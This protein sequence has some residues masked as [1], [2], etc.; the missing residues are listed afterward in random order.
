MGGGANMD[1]HKCNRTRK[2][3][4]RN[5]TN[6]KQI[7]NEGQSYKNDVAKRHEIKGDK[8]KPDINISK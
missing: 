4:F 3:V 1:S 5:C 7:Q 6:S 8:T 2:F